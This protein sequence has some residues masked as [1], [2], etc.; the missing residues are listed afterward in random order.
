MATYSGNQFLVYVGLHD[1]ENFGIETNKIKIQEKKYYHE[2][3][4]KINQK[5]G[6]GSVDSS[7]G[8]IYA[9]IKHH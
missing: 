6:A 2:L 7:S 8:S 5:Y 9:E 3:I 1:A 4:T